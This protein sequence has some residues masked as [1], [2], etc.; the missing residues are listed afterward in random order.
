MVSVPADANAG[1]GRHLEMEGDVMDKSRDDLLAQVRKDE[2]QRAERIRSLCRIAQRPELAQQYIDDGVTVA[3]AQAKLDELLA[4]EPAQAPVGKTR[5][6]TPG[7]DVNVRQGLADALAH[8]SALYEF[9]PDHKR[10]PEARALRERM[11]GNEFRGLS[12]G[13]LAAYCLKSQGVE[14]RGMSPRDCIYKAMQTRAVTGAISSLVADFPNLLADQINKALLTNWELAPETWPIWT[15]TSSAAD[16]KTG[17]RVHLSQFNRLTLTAENTAYPAGEPDDEAEPFTVKKYGALFHV[18][19]EALTN[20]DLSGLSRVPGMMGRA[21][22]ATVGD[23]VY[24]TITAN[25]LMSDA[26]ALFAAGHNNLVTTGGAPTQARVNA[27]RVAMALQTD[28]HAT[29][30][31]T[32]G[33]RMRYVLV[34]LELENAARVVVESTTNPVDNQAAG[35]INPLAVQNLMVIADHRLSD[36]SAVKWYGAADLGTTEVIFLNGQSSPMVDNE[37]NFDRD[38]IMYRVRLFFTAIPVD[39]RTFQQD[40][41]VT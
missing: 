30:P 25:P 9:S 27:L 40:D 17:S 34:P 4:A 33:I 38:G 10:L 26:V 13:D 8:R 41:G 18:S 14:T 23:V 6:A 2:K 1:I 37:P 22:S 3:G 7:D 11:V 19:I 35:I 32:L 36:D 12:I 29:E 28:N 20:D 5:K 15:Q 24:A 21:A 39:W 31:H 16:F